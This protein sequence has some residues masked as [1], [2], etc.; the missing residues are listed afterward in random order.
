MISQF[1]FA[2]HAYSRSASAPLLKLLE[3]RARDDRRCPVEP[4]F[5][6]HRVGVSQL[7]RPRLL[8]TATDCICNN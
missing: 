3:T 8:P 4:P 2:S 1:A 7:P 5:S 6:S